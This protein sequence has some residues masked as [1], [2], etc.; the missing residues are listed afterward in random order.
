MNT[1]CFQ[2]SSTPGLSHKFQNYNILCEEAG[3]F[4][5]FNIYQVQW[6]YN[7]RWICNKGGDL[8]SFII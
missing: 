1:K 5:A 2:N 4:V 3:L 7:E 8:A 6:G